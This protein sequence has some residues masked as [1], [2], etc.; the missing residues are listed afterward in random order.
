MN[1]SNM[2]KLKKVSGRWSKEDDDWLVNNYPILGSKGC[3]NQLGRSKKAITARCNLLGLRLVS[4]IKS[5]LMSKPASE[6]NVNPDS[7]YDIQDKEIA[8]FLGFM[9]ADGYLNASK[10]GSNHLIT[11]KILED[12]MVKLKPIFDN[13][14]KWNYYVRTHDNAG[15]RNTETMTT[16]NKRLFDF[17]VD[18][19]Y[20]EKSVA[21]PD[22]I[23]SKIP[24]DLK[25]Y[26]FLGLSDGDGCFYYYKPKTGSIQRQ[27]TITSSYEQ[28]WSYMVKLCD[29]MGIK[30]KIKLS[31]GVNPKTGNVNSSSQFRVTNRVGIQKLG[32]Y[33]Y[34][35]FDVDG[36]GLPRKYDKYQLI[37][38]G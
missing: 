8:Y 31:S 6:C 36:I 16:N 32:G 9:W 14:G 2:N 17:L 20:D 21:S 11:I 7:F 18:N 4:S 27:F 33:L 3:I 38:N 28:D 5:V 13:V 35:S 10:N 25:S 22:K 26:F 12:D 29:D 37:I 23:L 1:D 30:Y 24:D 15:W 34:K 19:G